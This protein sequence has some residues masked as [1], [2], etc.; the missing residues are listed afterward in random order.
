[1]ALKAVIF[2][3]EGIFF[4]VDGTEGHG[5]RSEHAPRLRQE[6]RALLDFL[7]EKGVLPVVVCNR[8]FTWKPDGSTAKPLEAFLEH[9]Y[10]PVQLIVAARGTVPLKPQGECIPAVVRIIGFEKHEV[11]MVGASD[12]DFKTSMNGRV[13]FLNATWDRQESSYGFT[14]DSPAKVQRFIDVFG[15]QVHPWYYAIDDEPVTF[16]SLGPFSTYREDF[17]DFSSAARAALKQITDDRH[18]FLQRLVAS[19]YFSGLSAGIDYVA[20]APPH[21][22]GHG[23]PA[24]DDVL[25]TFAGAIRSRFLID[26]VKRGREAP[27]QAATRRSRSQPKPD[28]QLSTILIEKFPLKTRDGE[29]YRTP[30]KLG[31]KRILVVDDFCTEGYTLDAVRN[32]LATVG[33]TMVGVSVL[34]TINTAYHRLDVTTRLNRFALTEVPAAGVRA[35]N[36]GYDSHIVDTAAVTELRESFEQFRSYRRRLAT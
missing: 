5:L 8:E 32:H 25:E 7:R 18:Y 30:I 14:F 28:A 20:V 24:F 23:D 6:L 11:A 2:G 16:R 17:A 15:L 9:Y 29:R 10:G 22:V 27:S 4:S 13:L 31:G 3:A 1:M 26:L 36:L 19:V 34:K 33:A 35:V 21:T 12:I